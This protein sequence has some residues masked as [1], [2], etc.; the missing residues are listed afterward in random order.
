MPIPSADLGSC[1]PLNGAAEP[2]A[3]AFTVDCRAAPDEH[4]P[5]K[6]LPGIP[7]PYPLP[8]PTSDVTERLSDVMGRCFRPA[9]VPSIM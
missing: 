5:P 3:A 7:R 2:R 9:P 1:H 6:Q 8:T 4:D